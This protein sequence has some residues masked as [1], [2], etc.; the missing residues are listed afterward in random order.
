MEGRNGNVNTSNPL[1]NDVVQI[2]GGDVAASSSVSSPTNGTATI[3]GGTNVVF[4]P[5][6]NFVGT[7][8]IGYTITDNIGQ[9]HE[10]LVDYSDGNQPVADRVPADALHDRKYRLA[11][12]TLAGIASGRSPAGRSSSS[13]NPAHGTLTGLNT[14]TGA[15]TYTPTNNFLGT[16]TFT[17]HVNNGVNN[18]SN[19]TIT[20]DVTP[21][22]DLVVQQSG[23][24]SGIAGSNL[25]FTVAVTNLGPAGATNVIVTNAD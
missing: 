13:G 25:V 15:V 17:F 2:T 24:L 21:I 5:T 10:H 8:T 1:L 19:A 23:P 6:L 3:L 12:I 11:R 20:I 4:I 16:D 9:W 18:S 7:A 14:N 22:A